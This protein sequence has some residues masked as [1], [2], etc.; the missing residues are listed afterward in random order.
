MLSPLEGIRVLEFGHYVYGPSCAKILAQLGADVIKVEP[1]EGDMARI[2]ESGIDSTV[3]LICNVGKR[4]IALNL[5]EPKGLEIVHKLISRVD[6][7]LENFRPGVMKRLGMDYQAIS[8]INL[9]IVYA[10]LSMYGEEGP[11]AHRRGADIWAQAFTGVVAGQG[12]PDGPPYLAGHA[13]IDLGGALSAALAIVA[14]LLLRKKTGKG[15]EVTTN[16]I[17]TGLY[18][19]STTFCYT[20]MDDVL[21]KKGGRGTARGQFPYG[22]YTAKDGDIAT[23][24]GQDDEEW[25][26]FCHILGIE[27]LLENPKYQTAKERTEHKFELYPILDEAFKKRTRNEWAELFK[28]NGLRCD[29]CLDY[30]EVLNHDQF[31]ALDLTVEVEHPVRGKIRVLRAPMEFKGSQR[32]QTYRHPPILGEHTREILTELGFKSHEVNELNDQGVVGIPIPSM[33]K[34][35]HSVLKEK[36]VR[37]GPPASIDL[38]R[39]VKRR[40]QATAP[41]GTKKSSSA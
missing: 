28:Q 7:V 24:F 14:A 17:S 18:L 35:I 34:P 22:V 16:L 9:R 23:L 36:I 30:Q 6:V 27:H 29:P 21:L 3:F 32:P 20:L 10:G 13:F 4:S 2:S 33:L 11:L 41:T 5:K 19:Q 12:N 38:G 25:P 1:L 15:Q 39:G 8:K 37:K 31:K 26:V 40:K